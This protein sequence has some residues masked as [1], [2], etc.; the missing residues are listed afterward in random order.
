MVVIVSHGFL[1]YVYGQLAKQ[2]L[3]SCLPS[4]SLLCAHQIVVKKRMKAPVVPV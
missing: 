1:G 3:L 2:C 4:H